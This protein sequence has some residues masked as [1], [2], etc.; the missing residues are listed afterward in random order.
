MI[1]NVFR[2]WAPQAMLDGVA[3]LSFLTH[4]SSLSKGVIDLRDLVFFGLVMVFWL[5]ANMIVLELKKAD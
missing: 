3:N 5:F 2:G 1:M 4:F